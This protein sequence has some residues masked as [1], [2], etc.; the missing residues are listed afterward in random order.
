MGLKMMIYGSLHWGC[1]LQ[2]TKI[3]LQEFSISPEI[4]QKQPIKHAIQVISQKLQAMILRRDHKEW[5]F[6]RKKRN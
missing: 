6:R 1:Q 3:K 4:K 5:L 2:I